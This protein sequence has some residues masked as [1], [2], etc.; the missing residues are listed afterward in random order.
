[1]H[2]LLS[3]GPW[4]LRLHRLLRHDGLRIE[5]IYALVRAALRNGQGRVQVHAFPFRM[6]ASNIDCYSDHEWID[7]WRNLKQGYDIFET[8]LRP[9]R[10]RMSGKRYVFDPPPL[11]VAGN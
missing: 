6:S 10:V 2:R 1:M 5:E 8:T 3:N 4:R 9:P 7:F 11:S